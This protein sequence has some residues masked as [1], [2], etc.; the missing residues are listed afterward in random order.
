MSEKQSLARR[1]YWAS[2]TPEERSAHARHAVK[3]RHA[4]MSAEEKLL[5]FKKK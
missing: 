4:K 5:L 3:A 2:R 1:E